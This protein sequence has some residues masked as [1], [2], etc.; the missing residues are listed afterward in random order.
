LEKS[1]AEYVE[2]KKQMDALKYGKK[3]HEALTTHTDQKKSEAMSPA[4]IKRP[5]PASKPAPRKR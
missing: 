1:E 3:Q 2:M 5:T 4:P